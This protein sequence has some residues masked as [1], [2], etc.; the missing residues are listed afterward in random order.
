MPPSPGWWFKSS[1]PFASAFPQLL[2]EGQSPWRKAS[3]QSGELLGNSV[4]EVV[5]DTS[6]R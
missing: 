2:V 6:R 4:G 5:Q 3:V 1:G